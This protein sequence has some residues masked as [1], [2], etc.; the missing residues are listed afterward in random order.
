[1]KRAIDIFGMAVE[2]RD[3]A[4]VI[5]LDRAC[6]DDAALRAEVES[7]LEAH[8]AAGVF[9]GEPTQDLDAID[10]PTI[11]SKDSQVI[12]RHTGP[13]ESPGQMIGRRSKAQPAPV[14]APRSR[15]APS[16][17]PPAVIGAGQA[18]AGRSNPAAATYPKS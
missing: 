12:R 14:V 15:P 2:F 11:G 10:P 4:R 18:G 13:S 5:C 17:A 9:L 3:Q 16:L 6:G 1:M 7:L 8:A